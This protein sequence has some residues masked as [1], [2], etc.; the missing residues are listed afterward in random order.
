[1]TAPDLAQI[2]LCELEPLAYDA[3]GRACMDA[4]ELDRLLDVATTRA[5][6]AAEAT[7]SALAPGVVEAAAALA[8]SRC[9]LV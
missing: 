5:C 9:S 4:V 6:A 7:G 8:L 1:M 3:R 2:I